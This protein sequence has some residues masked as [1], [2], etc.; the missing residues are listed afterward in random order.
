L[1]LKTVANIL[2][3]ET[4]FEVFAVELDEAAAML[5]GEPKIPATMGAAGLVP[6]ILDTKVFF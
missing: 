3:E 1:F 4:F 6:D 2:E 5:S